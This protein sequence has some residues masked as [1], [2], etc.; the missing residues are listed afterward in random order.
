MSAWLKG[1]S[2]SQV[3]GW[4]PFDSIMKHVEHLHGSYIH[5]TAFIVYQMIHEIATTSL[6]FLSEMFSD[7]VGMFLFS[8]DRQTEYC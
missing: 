8:F 4:N 7:D 3:V 2:K 1:W 5:V 6:R